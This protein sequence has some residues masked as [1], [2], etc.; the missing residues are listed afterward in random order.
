ML[1]LHFPN[2]DLLIAHR[3]VL[4]PMRSLKC[5]DSED[6]V[7][8]LLLAA[9]MNSATLERLR[10]FWMRWELDA[11]RLTRLSDRRLI[12]RVAR[13]A[14]QGPLAAFVV[15]NR[16][17][18]KSELVARSLASSH[19]T[20]KTLPASGPAPAYVPKTS[21]AAARPV[22]PQQGAAVEQKKAGAPA[23]AA[24]KLAETAP[25]PGPAVPDAIKVQELPIEQ[26]IEQVL[27]RIPKYLPEAMRS[28]FA[29]VLQPENLIITVAV[30]AV[31][32][33]SHAVGVGFI[34]D[35]LLLATGLV[36]MGF[37]V[38]G[39]AEKIGQALELISAAK[40]EED[41][42]EA[43]KLL[44]EVIGALG[45]AVFMALIAR[46]AGRVASSAVKGKGGS[47]IR[48][49]PEPKST[50]PPRTIQRPPPSPASKPA[51]VSTT[52]KI[53]YHATH[54][55]AANA[56]K[57]GGFKPGTKPGR[58]GSGGVYVNDTPEGAAA[59]F[60][61][62]NPGVK[63]AIIEVEYEPGVN[64]TATVPPRTYVTEHPLD[65]ESISAPSLRA[66]GTLNTNILNG[67]AK[68][69]G[70]VE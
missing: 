7:R 67:S 28:D 9:L 40:E 59:E 3:A 14:V 8:R 64:A 17:I 2:G 68:P 52:K 38:F 18:A 12:D 32:A 65:V 25:T 50:P 37:A 69:I 62:H 47:T 34:L 51:P 21:D 58:L 23:F 63:P 29:K 49:P 39:V 6:E 70:V 44:A 46:G 66:P 48:R 60:A 53:G 31:W 24:T 13:M 36:T 61:H 20:K 54:P 55:E 35:A 22:S 11:S 56:I 42:E 43:A 4:T 26:K 30:L 33:V 27:R 41:L 5:L 57:K 1:R 16:P 15:H 45:V 10:Q 19:V